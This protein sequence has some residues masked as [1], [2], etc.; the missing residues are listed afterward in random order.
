M[1]LEVYI[2]GIYLKGT[3]SK[4]VLK[5]PKENFNEDSLNLFKHYSDRKGL[6]QDRIYCM[7][8][9]DLHLYI[10]IDCKCFLDDDMNLIINFKELRDPVEFVYG[11]SYIDKELL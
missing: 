2:T 11:K 10:L 1:E 7:D 4:D 6:L 5:I 3:L 8:N 9:L